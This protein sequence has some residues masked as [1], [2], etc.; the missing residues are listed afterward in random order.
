MVELPRVRGTCFELAAVAAN[1]AGCPRE[2]FGTPPL[3]RS[4]RTPAAACKTSAQGPV[5]PTRGH[6]LDLPARTRYIGQLAGALLADLDK[7]GVQGIFG[8]IIRHFRAT[9][10]VRSVH[11]DVSKKSKR[12]TG[13]TP[14]RCRGELEEGRHRSQP[15]RRGKVD[16]SLSR[17][18]PFP[19]FPRK[20]PEPAI[21]PHLTSPHR[22]ERD[23]LVA[24][25]RC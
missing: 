13:A 14:P 20:G 19:L 8:R 16:P 25:N 22:W 17:G 18:T 2:Q 11:D 21:T 23:Q 5:S 6:C 24:K 7:W 3:C 9:A 4:L 12:R 15:T 10:V 1:A